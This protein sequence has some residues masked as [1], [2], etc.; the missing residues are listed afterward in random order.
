MHLHSSRPGWQSVILIMFLSKTEK[1]MFRAILVIPV[2][3]C[4]ATDVGAYVGHQS[5][6][7]NGI[8]LNGMSLQGMNLQGMELQGV[9]MQGVETKAHA[10]LRQPIYASNSLIVDEIILPTGETVNLR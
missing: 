2:V 10:P 3:M 1:D 4:L 9:N 5:T 7:L 6:S 8:S